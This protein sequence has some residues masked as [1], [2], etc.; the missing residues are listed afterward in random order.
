MNLGL[1]VAAAAGTCIA[2]AITFADRR[3]VT[4]A[5]AVG[6]CAIGAWRGAAAAVPDRGAGSVS[7]HL[8]SG[9]MVLRGTVADAGV[10]GRGDTIVVDVHDLATAAGTWH[11]AGAAVVEPR[12]PT[13][14]LPG[15]MI[16]VQTA[17]LRAPPQRPG[18]LS[19]VALERVGVTAIASAAQVTVLS[20]GGPS[21]AR[22]AQQLRGAL[23]AVVARA[24]PEPE[25]TLVLGVAFG[26]H[27]R[28]TT[29]VRA[30]LQDAGL[31]HVVAVSGLMTY[32]YVYGHERCHLCTDLARR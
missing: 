3:V 19:V 31:I 6:A 2:I 16:D 20:Q 1:T 29:A 26:I 23:G 30:P 27:A 18:S 12:S 9:S 22:V 14:V 8:G 10:P 24:L 5:V 32:Y 21:P 25:A 17:S 7:G 11:V 4:A 28:I 13:A 15:D